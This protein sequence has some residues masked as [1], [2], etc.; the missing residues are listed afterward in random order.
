M[1][2]KGIKKKN[3]RNLVVCSDCGCVYDSKI[4]KKSNGVGIKVCPACQSHWTEKL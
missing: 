2:P 1:T 4:S 3:K